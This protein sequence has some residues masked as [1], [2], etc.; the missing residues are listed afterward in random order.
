MKK[1]PSE[2]PFVKTNSAGKTSVNDYAIY[3]HIKETT[4]ICIIG[5]T[6]FI[7]SNGVY[8][9]DDTGATL[10]GMITACLLDNEDMI[11]SHVQNRIYNLF[12]NDPS[13]HFK[14]DDMNNYPAE[15][16]MFRDIIYDPVR[17]TFHEH[18]PEYRSINMVDVDYPTEKDDLTEEAIKGSNAYKWL[19]GLFPEKDDLEM[20][21]EYLGY[22][23]TTDTRQQKFL[24]IEGLPGA[25]KSLIIKA[26]GQIVG[27]K[28]VS[29]LPLEKMSHRF[30]SY[31]LVGK[32]VN[33]C[34]DISTSMLDDITTIKQAIGEDYMQ[35]EAKG[36]DAI[37]FKPYAKL[38]F[39]ANGL[40]TIS[41]EQSAG[42]YRRVL[43]AKASHNVEETDPMFF[44]K[45]VKPD[46]YILLTM[47]V[48]AL[49]R[50]Y[51]NKTIR[52]SEGSKQ[53]V[54]EMWN[55]SDPVKAWLSACTTRKAGER[56]NKPYAYTM[57]DNYRFHMQ[58]PQIS[59]NVFY[60][61]LKA[62]GF[63]IV[64]SN[65]SEYI[66]GMKITSSG[67][68]IAQVPETDVKQKQG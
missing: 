54:N 39:S 57:F 22:C 18:D 35:A 48:K 58:L 52:E 2:N 33:S 14:M 21:L 37:S 53:M 10:K 32:L 68:P 62:K 65:G 67:I 17:K 23:L 29:T 7:Y 11:T 12:I 42:F 27:H 25:G 51:E 41:N 6:P 46:L 40:P 8:E 20:V 31:N 49:E 36:K 64:K 34:G 61:S 47:I 4:P 45:V 15:W 50:M 63:S 19:S 24:I 26:L 28:N 56:E 43:I 9:Q 59:R 30:A 5:G 13:L 16:I 38:L 44:E 55:N 3:K 1:N 66:D 60:A